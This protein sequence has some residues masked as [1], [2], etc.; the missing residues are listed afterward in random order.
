MSSSKHLCVQDAID[1]EFFAIFE[2]KLRL[3]DH[4]ENCYYS[5]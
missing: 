4:G 1:F 5:D 2:H 3:K